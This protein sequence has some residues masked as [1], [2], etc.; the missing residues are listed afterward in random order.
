MSWSE[1][2]ISFAASVV[3]FVIDELFTFDSLKVSDG[4][5]TGVED[6]DAAGFWISLGT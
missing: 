6:V 5:F 1:L 4:I 3:I 2:T